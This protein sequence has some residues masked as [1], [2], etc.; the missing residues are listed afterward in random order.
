MDPL[1]RGTAIHSIL[2]NFLRNSGDA[3]FQSASQKTLQDELERQAFRELERVRPVGIPDLLWE[4]ERDSLIAM[5]RNWVQF[6]IQ[7]SESDMRVARLEQSFGQF[8]GEQ[9]FAAFEV[10]AGKHK[11]RFRGRIDRVDVSRDGKRARVIDYKTGALPESMSGNNRTPLMSGERIQVV[12]YR[13]ALKS[14]DQFKGV[15]TIDGEYLH[16]Q[17]KDGETAPC[18]FGD[19]ELQKA[20]QVLPALLEIVGD[21]IE[22]GIFFARTSGA[23]RP[24]GHCEYCDYLTIC[25]KERK[26]REE[27]KAK[28]PAVVRFLGIPELQP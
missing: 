26:Q 17:P 24:G 27:R 14:L 2:E 10:R 25:G 1:A 12:V 6:E 9:E 19:E 15:E 7:R 13:G 11:F 8:G 4:I 3:I 21:G 28:D 22:G 16:L 23:V 5:L 18:S 20:A